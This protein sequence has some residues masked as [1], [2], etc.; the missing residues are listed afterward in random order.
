MRKFSSLLEM[1]LLKLK[2]EPEC[3]Y[4]FRSYQFVDGH[5]TYNSTWVQSPIN[6][7]EKK[8]KDRVLGDINTYSKKGEEKKIPWERLGSGQ[9]D[10]RINHHRKESHKSNKENISRRE[11]RKISGVKGREKLSKSGKVSIGFGKIEVTDDFDK[12]NF[13]GVL[14]AEEP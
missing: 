5:F 4:K 6:E 13:Y 2:R 7:F 8:A 14:R 1:H 12:I 11:I 10:R 3:K 9:Q